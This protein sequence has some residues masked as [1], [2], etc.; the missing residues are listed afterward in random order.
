[1]EHSPAI[2]FLLAGA[3]LLSIPIAWLLIR[4]A[5]RN[6]MAWH[7]HEFQSPGETVPRQRPTAPDAIF[8]LAIFGLLAVIFGVV[9][10]LAAGY[11]GQERDHAVPA[12]P[13]SR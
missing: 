13:Y 10:L 7:R 12:A 11:V 3:S 4:S 6:G 5:V 2:L 1:M 9:G 8:L